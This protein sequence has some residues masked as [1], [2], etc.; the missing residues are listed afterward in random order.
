MH[1]S[2]GVAVAIG[3]VSLASS[4]EG[5]AFDCMHRELPRSGNG[6]LVA[7]GLHGSFRD[8]SL[9]P[10][11]VCASTVETLAPPGEQGPSPG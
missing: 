11:K 4:R 1:V 8:L 5:G 6:C 9:R 7:P 3:D 10:H 2:S